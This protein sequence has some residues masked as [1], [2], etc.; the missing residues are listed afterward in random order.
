MSTNVKS[1]APDVIIFPPVI[2][3]ST[4]LISFVLQRLFPIETLSH[5]DWP[6]RWIAGFAIAIIGLFV[7]AT[8]IYAM[9][10]LGTN[11][12]PSSP[13][14][15]LVTGGVFRFTRNPIYVGGS[16]LM[17]GLAL[18]SANGWLL[19]LFVPSQ[20][21]LH[22]GVVLREEHYLQAKF[23]D[24]YLRYKANTPRYIWPI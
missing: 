18:I 17:I 10:R 16:L 13:T 15:A 12:S 1:D 4:I 6:L 3:V 21:I 24:A 8:A 5:I 2:I 20:L 11:V 23:G 14:T 19:I 7:G 22:W 9:A